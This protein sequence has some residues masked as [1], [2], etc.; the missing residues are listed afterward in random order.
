[1]QLANDDS[2]KFAELRLPGRLVGGAHEAL[3]MMRGLGQGDVEGV[4]AIP[5]AM[6]P[7]GETARPVAGGVGKG[8]HD[9]AGGR[10]RNAPLRRDQRKIAD[11][12]AHPRVGLGLGAGDQ[13]PIRRVGNILEQPDRRVD[14]ADDAMGGVPGDIGD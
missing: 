6:A 1:M 3:E 4:T 11:L 8:A 12:V 2:A 5:D 10:A 7:I 14:R 9:Q 13:V